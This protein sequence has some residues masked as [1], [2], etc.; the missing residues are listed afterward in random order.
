MGIERLFQTKEGKPMGMSEFFRDDAGELSCMRLMV[1]F[2]DAVVLGIWI[3]ANIKAGHY[4]PLGYAEAGIICANHGGK[5][6]QG[7]FEYGGGR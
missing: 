1:F 4:V 7:Y 2:V 5:A 3:W 6:A